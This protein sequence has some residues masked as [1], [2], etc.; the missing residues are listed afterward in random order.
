[1]IRTFVLTRES[2]PERIGPGAVSL[3]TTLTQA[4]LTMGLETDDA[5]QLHRSG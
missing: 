3:Y 2:R 1:V 5:R 4:E